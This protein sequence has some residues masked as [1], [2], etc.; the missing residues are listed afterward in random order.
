MFWAG[1]MPQLNETRCSTVPGIRGE[2]LSNRGRNERENR[3][4]DVLGCSE[5]VAD[6]VLVWVLVC[7]LLRCKSFGD[8][9]VEAR[10]VEPLFLK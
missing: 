4:F 8:R 1:R 3:R 7:L 6:R 9:V 10:G 5:T 2:R